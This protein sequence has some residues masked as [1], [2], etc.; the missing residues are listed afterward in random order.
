MAAIVTRPALLAYVHVAYWASYALLVFEM[1]HVKNL[2]A[3]RSDA[4][5]EVRAEGDAR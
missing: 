1:A 2:L 4:V 5:H 3:V